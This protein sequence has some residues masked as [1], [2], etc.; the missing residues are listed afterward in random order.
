MF[1]SD[2]DKRKVEKS[3]ISCFKGTTVEQNQQTDSRTTIE[4]AT[5]KKEKNSLADLAKV[6][7]VAIENPNKKDKKLSI[8]EEIEHFRATCTQS[9]V[10]FDEYWHNKASHLPMLA[11]LVKK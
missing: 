3:I 5:K 6:C 8:R 4:M 1:L 2:A 11:S 10:R 7:G 9:K